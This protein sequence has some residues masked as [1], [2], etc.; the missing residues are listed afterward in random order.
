MNPVFWLLVV[1]FAIG[2]WFAISPSF[3]SIGD[4]AINIVKNAKEEMLNEEEESED[5]EE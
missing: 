2:I 3:N 4:R 5:E 1:L